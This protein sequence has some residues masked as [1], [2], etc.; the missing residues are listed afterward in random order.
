MLPLLPSTMLLE[1]QVF[2][3]FTEI[4]R[5][6]Q[7]YALRKELLSRQYRQCWI[8]QNFKRRLF[9]NNLV[10]YDFLLNW[11]LLK[12][13]VVFFSRYFSSY[14]AYQLSNVFSGV[15]AF[16]FRIF[17]KLIDFQ[18]NFF[19]CDDFR[20]TVDKFLHFLFFVRSWGNRRMNDS[21]WSDR[22]VLSN[23]LNT[24]NCLIVFVLL[25]GRFFKVKGEFLMVRDAHIFLALLVSFSS[26]SFPFD[27][28][29]SL[30]K[31]RKW[32]YLWSRLNSLC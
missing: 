17:F 7:V 28:S 14:F 4:H 2:S 32:K 22:R 18:L 11:K 16:V 26:A 23:F 3:V 24:L 19:S 25:S 6:N 9:M 15:D 12:V 31:V 20:Q 10:S 27:V 29:E 21:N 13:I 8:R 5:P 1:K 30:S